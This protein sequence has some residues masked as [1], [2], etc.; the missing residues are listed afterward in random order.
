MKKGSLILFLAA[1]VW[2]FCLVGQATGMDAMG[3]I[4]F[5][6]VRL[7]LGGVSMI[8]LVL[9]LDWRKKGR[10][11]SAKDGEP[12]NNQGLKDVT[13]LESAV[14][15]QDSKAEFKEAFRAAIICVPFILATILCQQYGLLHTSVGKCAFITAFNIFLVPVFG[16]FF[17]QKASGKIWFS[18]VLAIAGLYLITMSSGFDGINIGD[19]ICFGA[20]VA[21]SIYIKLLESKAAQVDSIKFSMIQF[22][23]CGLICFILAPII[24]PGQITWD[25]YVAGIWPIL[26][27]GIVSCAG[28][29]TLQI[30]GQ[31]MVDAN[32]SSLILSSETVFSLFAGLIFLHEVLFVKEYIGCALMTVAIIISV[33]PEKTEKNEKEFK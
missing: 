25:S 16:V 7:T 33:I 20:A 32:K 1:F 22:T 9:V 4:S 29:Y 18:V 27:T 14:S 30:I 12:E 23:L 11:S 5:S 13:E 8:P 26:I 10:N 19:V 24:E 31:S 21:Y 28:G 15:N 2:G 6:A 3:P 17:G